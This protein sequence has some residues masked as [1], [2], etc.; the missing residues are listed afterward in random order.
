LDAKTIELERFA[1]MPVVEMV[2][3]SLVSGGYQ[4]ALGWFLAPTNVARRFTHHASSSRVRWIGSTEGRG[5]RWLGPAAWARSSAEAAPR[6]SCGAATRRRLSRRQA[7][8][9][10]LLRRTI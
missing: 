4:D 6:L 9:D 5:G 2:C 8:H 3:F 1:G 10:F 7:F